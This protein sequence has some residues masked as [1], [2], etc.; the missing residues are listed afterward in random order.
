MTRYRFPKPW[1]PRTKDRLRR[2]L[3]FER[4]V[5]ASIAATCAE[6]PDIPT[7]EALLVLVRFLATPLNAND[8]KTARPWNLRPTEMVMVAFVIDAVRRARKEL[9]A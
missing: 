6:S 2:W 7:R 9:A 3:P 1:T 5:I 4:K 8:P